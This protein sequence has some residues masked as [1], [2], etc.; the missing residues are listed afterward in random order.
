MQRILTQKEVEEF[1]FP[2]LLPE[3]RSFDGRC[4]LRIQN[5]RLN[6]SNLSKSRRIR[7]AK[8]TY[9]NTDMVPVSRS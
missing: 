9:L 8:R 7:A 5:S 4:R 1:D 6:Y 3:F 2:V